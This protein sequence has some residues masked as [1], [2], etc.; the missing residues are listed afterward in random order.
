MAMICCMG[1]YGSGKSTSMRTLDPEKTLIAN[2]L[3]KEFPF[4]QR[5]KYVLNG[6]DINK[7]IDQITKAVQSGIKI[8][9]I[10]DIGYVMIQM[11]MSRHR[12]MKGN[13]SFELYNDIA[14]TMWSF[15][16]FCKSLPQ[17]VNIYL[18]FHEETNDYGMTKIKTIGKLLDSKVGIEGMTTILLRFMTKDGK[19]F[20]RTVTDG[21][22]VAKSPFDLFDSEEIPNDLSYI[23][24][25]IREY[26]GTQLKEETETQE[27]TEC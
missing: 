11:F 7:I 18:M 8:I 27:V 14:D 9:V 1:E 23:D 10:D 3:S 19:H 21:S 5:F 12:N 22:D 20:V 24:N 26:Y 15:I 6:W 4:R 17:D 16:N 13:Q 2:V 25:C